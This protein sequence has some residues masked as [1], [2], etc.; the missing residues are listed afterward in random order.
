M[1]ATYSEPIDFFNNCVCVCG[2]NMRLEMYPNIEQFSCSKCGNR[3]I[4]NEYDKERGEII[5]NVI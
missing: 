4:M 2:S 3:L 1:Q 5:N